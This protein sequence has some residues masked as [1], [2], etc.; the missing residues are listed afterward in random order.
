MTDT[1]KEAVERLCKVGFGY[2]LTDAD[3]AMIRALK[4]TS[5]EGKG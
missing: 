2:D 4:S 5:T 3:K 1:S